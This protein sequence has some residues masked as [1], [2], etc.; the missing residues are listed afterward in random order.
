MCIFMMKL[1][2]YDFHMRNNTFKTGNV[3]C[4]YF[5]AVQETKHFFIETKQ[6]EGTCFLLFFFS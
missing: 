5:S 1:Y 6:G 3:S 2:N 4:C